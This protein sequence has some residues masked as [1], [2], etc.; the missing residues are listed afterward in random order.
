MLYLTSN[1]YSNRSAVKQIPKSQIFSKIFYWVS[2]HFN[3]KAIDMSK[4]EQL[5]DLGQPVIKGCTEGNRSSQNKLK[6]Y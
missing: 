6:Y 5:L 4:Y 3:T 1:L 2:T